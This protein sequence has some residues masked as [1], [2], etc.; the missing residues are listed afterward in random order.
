MP[1]VYLKKGQS[2]D[3]IEQLE[4]VV[5]GPDHPETVDASKRLN[6]CKTV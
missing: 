5:Q 6:S 3:V 4:L 1:L 2:N